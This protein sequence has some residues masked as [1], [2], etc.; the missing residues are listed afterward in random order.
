MAGRF[1]ASPTS[2]HR[3][4]SLVSLRTQSHR[5]S[6]TPPQRG[7]KC[8]AARIAKRIVGLLGARR[9]QPLSPDGSFERVA[10]N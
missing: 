3:E 4:G 8:Q 5:A 1:R 10:H 9:R 2:F 7:K 6:P